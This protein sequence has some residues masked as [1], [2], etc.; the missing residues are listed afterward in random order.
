MTILSL[1]ELYYFLGRFRT[2]LNAKRNP[3]NFKGMILSD[4]DVV[5]V[6]VVCVTF[7]VFFTF[8]MLTLYETNW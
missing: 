2:F 5:I 3:F 1:H 4:N 6:Y 7:Y 8:L